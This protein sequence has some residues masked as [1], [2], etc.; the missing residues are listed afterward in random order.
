M[1]LSDT[2]QIVYILTLVFVLFQHSAQTPEESGQPISLAN[3]LYSRYGFCFERCMNDID[4]YIEKIDDSMKNICLEDMEYP[5][6]DVVMSII[7]M[8]DFFSKTSNIRFYAKKGLIYEKI[9][10]LYYCHKCITS[11]CQMKDEDYNN[12]YHAFRELRLETFKLCYN[13]Y[14]ISNK[15]YFDVRISHSEFQNEYNL[16]YADYY[17]LKEIYSDLRKIF[18][19]ENSRPG[20]V[21]SQKTV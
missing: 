17:K 14:S 6:L 4:N 19:Y 20:Q 13:Y 10:H 9:D 3:D 12:I 8:N 5:G 18:E 2:A 1:I 15:L 11:I 7:E 21:I 16:L